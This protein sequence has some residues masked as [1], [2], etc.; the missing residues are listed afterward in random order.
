MLIS[1]IIS[2]V[3]IIIANIMCFTGFINSFYQKSEFNLFAN[4]GSRLCILDILIVQLFTSE[5]FFFH[6]YVTP[7]VAGTWQMVGQ[8]LGISY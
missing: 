5:S 7:M 6:R 3:K 8:L 2:D 1:V 4:T